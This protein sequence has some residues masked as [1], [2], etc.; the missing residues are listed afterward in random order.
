MLAQGYA[1][2]FQTSSLTVTRTAGEW[3]G[4]FVEQMGLFYLVLGI[5]GWI[6]LGMQRGAARR[7]AALLALTGLVDL[8]FVLNYRVGDPEVFLLPLL[9]VLAVGVGMGTVWLFSR[10]EM[11][12]W[13]ADQVAVAMLLVGIAMQGVG[14][15]FVPPVYSWTAHDQAVAMAKVDFPPDSRVIGIVGEVT[16]LKYMQQ[17]AGL[18]L[19]ALPVAADDPDLRRALGGRRMWPPAIRSSSHGN[20]RGSRTSIASPGPVPWCG[21]GPGA[22]P[23]PARLKWHC[24]G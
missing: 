2:F 8:L 12:L 17:S 21:C 3:L 24:P 14:P 22:R 6:W 23:N 15:G 5:G 9:M 4:F 11:T 13:S 20:W 16:A 1:G 19:N 7:I 18:G 10:R